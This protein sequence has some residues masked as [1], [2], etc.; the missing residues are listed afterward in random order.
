LVV[1]AFETVA[2]QATLEREKFRTQAMKGQFSAIQDVPDRLFKPI[3]TQLQV[4][5]GELLKIENVIQAYQSTKVSEL[6]EL[7]PALEPL[8]AAANEP[9]PSRV[10]VEQIATLSLHDLGLELAARRHQWEQMSA[11]ALEGS[12]MTM[13]EWIPLAKAI[14][15]GVSPSID[16]NTQAVLVNK[17][18][19][20]V[21]LAFGV[22]A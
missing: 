1:D 11:K 6:N 8:Y 9:A 7:L 13:V 20:K 22:G 10:A 14:L 18:V 17:G 4:L 21:R 15:A 19:L 3:Q 12:G 5:G 2:E 16:V